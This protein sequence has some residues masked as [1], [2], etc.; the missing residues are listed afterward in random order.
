MQHASQKSNTCR[1]FSQKSSI[2]ANVLWSCA[3]IGLNNCPL[4]MCNCYSERTQHVAYSQGSN[5]LWGTW[6][7]NALMSWFRKIKRG[8]IVSPPS[9]SRRVIFIQIIQANST[10]ILQTQRDPHRWFLLKDSSPMTPH[11]FLQT[12]IDP[13]PRFLLNGSSSMIPPRL[14]DSISTILPPWLI[15]HQFLLH[16]L[17]DESSSTILPLWLLLYDSCSTILPT[18]LTLLHDSSSMVPPQQI[19][20]SQSFSMIF[21]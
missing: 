16:V 13:P 11:R 4:S 10:Q 19:L 5:L 12:Q 9:L 17:L 20:V 18:W 6:N 8:Y 21:A 1:T 2:V 15:P 14:E 3:E 7:S